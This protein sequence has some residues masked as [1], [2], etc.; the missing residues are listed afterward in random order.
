MTSERY[1]AA[2]SLMRRGHKIAA[3]GGVANVQVHRPVTELMLA[4]ATSPRRRVLILLDRLTLDRQ[5]R[6]MPEPFAAAVAVHFFHLGDDVGHARVVRH[7]AV[8]DVGEIDRAVGA[9]L[10]V[11][12]ADRTPEGLDVA[13]HLRAERV[14]AGHPIAVE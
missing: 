5:P 2:A 6:R 1:V 10:P 8:V 12:K 11:V 14:D 4:S 13:E 9:L 3:T 7:P